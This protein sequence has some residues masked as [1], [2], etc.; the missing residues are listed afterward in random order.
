[1]RIWIT[2]GLMIAQVGCTMNARQVT[3]SRNFTS[4]YLRDDEARIKAL[5]ELLRSQSP[6]RTKCEKGI[7][8]IL[9]MD[10]RKPASRAELFLGS[11]SWHWYLE[12]WLN[13]YSSTCMGSR[14]PEH[15]IRLWSFLDPWEKRFYPG[16]PIG[17]S[18]PGGKLVAYLCRLGYLQADGSNYPHKKKIKDEDKPK[19]L[20]YAMRLWDEAVSAANPGAQ[21]REPMMP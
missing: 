21:L 5:F 10:G 12:F 19:I 15:D 17:V 11:P 8:I 3:T 1:M 14:N 18:K 9:D 4:Q 6:A 7:R 13:G 2:S 16:E 20:S